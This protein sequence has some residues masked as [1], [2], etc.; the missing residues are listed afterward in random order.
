M[1]DT[2]NSRQPGPVSKE[3]WPLPH[4]SS[5]VIEILFIPEQAGLQHPC[6]WRGEDRCERLIEVVHSGG[7][8]VT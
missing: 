3:G 2:R 5:N 6:H 1:V 8:L 4:H 7:L